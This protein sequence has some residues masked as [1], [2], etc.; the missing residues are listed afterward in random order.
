[1]RSVTMPLSGPNYLI[2]CFTKH[3]TVALSLIGSINFQTISNTLQSIHHFTDIRSD[4][5]P[6]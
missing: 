4:A 6:I 5:L 2:N 3:Y 1:M